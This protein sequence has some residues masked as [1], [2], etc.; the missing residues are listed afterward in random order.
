MIDA[1]KTRKTEL[2]KT[3]NIYIQRIET[4]DS[5][6]AIKLY[7]FTRNYEECNAR[8]VVIDPHIAFGKMTIAGTGIPIDIIIERFCAGDSYELL[9]YDYECNIDKIKEVIRFNNP[10]IAA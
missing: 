3:L 5:G 4:D 9:A 1:S 7:P 8:V 2:T 6:L 10:P